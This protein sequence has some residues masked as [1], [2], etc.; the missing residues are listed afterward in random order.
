MLTTMVRPVRSAPG[1]LLMKVRRVQQH[2]AREFARGGSGDDLTAEA[3]L[4]EQRNTS[5]VIE[6][7]VGEKQIVDLGRI[8]TKGTGILLVEF[9]TALKQAAVDQN[10]AAG[11]V[12]HVAGPGD[13]PVGAVEGQS[14]IDLTLI[15][16]PALRAAPV[17]RS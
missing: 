11:T 5:A 4:D 13:A 12:H 14:Q 1:L 8:E 3:P 17:K 6:V 2:E 16:E 9:A 7:R 10:A 15:V